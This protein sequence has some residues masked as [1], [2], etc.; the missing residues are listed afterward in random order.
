MSLDDNRKKALDLAFTQIEQNGVVSTWKDSLISG[1]LKK[2][3]HE[4]IQVPQFGVY[5]DI[6][7]EEIDGIDKV[8][9]S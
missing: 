7:E 4:F 9:K 8:M 5:R 3:V 1:R 2:E 6:Q